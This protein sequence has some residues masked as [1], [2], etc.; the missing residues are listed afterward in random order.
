VQGIVILRLIFYC[1]L[2]SKIDIASIFIIHPANYSSGMSIK[3]LPYKI[4]VNPGD[5]LDEIN[6]Q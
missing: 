5:S 1:F 3:K 4:K 2:Q 6:M